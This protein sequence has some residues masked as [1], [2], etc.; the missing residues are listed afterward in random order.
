MPEQS[1]NI[2]LPPP[3]PW[4]HYPLHEASLFAGTYQD[5]VTKGRLWINR[6]IFCEYGGEVSLSAKI[7]DFFEQKNS[8]QNGLIHE[9]VGTEQCKVKFGYKTTN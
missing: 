6:G 2:S 9:Q 4:C 7:I 3:P 5:K 8:V 1:K